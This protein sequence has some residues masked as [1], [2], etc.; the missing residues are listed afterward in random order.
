MP[1][2]N[3]YI[4]LLNRNRFMANGVKRE[5]DMRVAWE[6]RAQRVP[7]PG[8]WPV[9]VFITVYEP[10]RRRDWD[11]SLA[12]AEKTVLDGLQLAGVLPND[13]LAHVMP[14]VP[15]VEFDRERPRVE[16]EIVEGEEAWKERMRGLCTSSS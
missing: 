10:N 7:V 8:T 13:N 16:V 9:A 4:H 14:V 15:W 11:G 1:S 6:A 3:A 2:F 5:W 12:F